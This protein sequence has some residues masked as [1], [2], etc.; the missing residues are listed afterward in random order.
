MNVKINHNNSP[1]RFL[2]SLVLFL[3]GFSVATVSA[4]N[5][6]PATQDAQ[7][8]S[9][10]EKKAAK[11]TMKKKAMP[12]GDAMTEPAADTS[13]VQGDRSD[14]A[15][16]KADLSGTYTGKVDYPDANL[17]G[18][19]TL[20]IE[21]DKFTLTS[22]SDSK[23]GT[24]SGVDTK[25]YVGAAMTFGD[26]GSGGKTVSVRA[27]RKGNS[28]ILKSV[29]GELQKFSFTTAAKAATHKKKV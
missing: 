12:A 7:N 18:D 26:V 28:L 22:G 5:T 8:T 14:M 9:A 6:P 23:T 10:P 16:E 19:A 1:L 21:G 13:V 25:N 4:Q 11:K 20:A 24:I 17:S 29:E 2:F 27:I 3:L 15:G